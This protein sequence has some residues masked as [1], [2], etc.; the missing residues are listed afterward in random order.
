LSHRRTTYALGGAAAIA[1]LVLLALSPFLYA[2]RNLRLAVGAARAG[3]YWDGDRKLWKSADQPLVACLRAARRGDRS[4]MEIVV[5]QHGALT[6]ELFDVRGIKE[7]S[8]H[9]A[10]FAATAQPEVFFAVLE[11]QADAKV[12]DVLLTLH[13]SQVGDRVNV[14]WA[15]QIHGYSPSDR[16]DFRIE[17]AE[18]MFRWGAGQAPPRSRPMYRTGLELIRRRWPE[19]LARQRRKREEFLRRERERGVK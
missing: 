4:A 10:W 18:G 13:L 9:I 12:L 19:E 6:D 7:R 16:P 15:D 17:I 1:L 8:R 11:E 5:L 3:D 2:R 14:S